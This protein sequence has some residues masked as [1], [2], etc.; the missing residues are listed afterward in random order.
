MS[1]SAILRPVALQAPLSMGI[2]H[3]KTGMTCR[4]L[5]QG[6]FQFRERTC[7]S[8][9]LHRQGGYLPPVPLEKSLYTYISV[10]PIFKLASV[11]TDIIPI[12]NQSISWDKVPRKHSGHKLDLVL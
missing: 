3:V 8:R 9:F 6:S 10:F 11:K 5:L 2:L 4:F 7:I 12:T 1:D